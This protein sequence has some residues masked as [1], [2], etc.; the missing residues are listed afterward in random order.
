MSRVG[1]R[2]PC[3]DKSHRSGSVTNLQRSSIPVPSSASAPPP[4]GYVR[5]RVESRSR[6]MR[7]AFH[8]VCVCVGGGNGGG[9]NPQ[10]HPQGEASTYTPGATAGTFSTQFRLWEWP[11]NGADG[12]LRKPDTVWQRRSSRA[13]GG[14]SRGGTYLWHIGFCVWHSL[15]CPRCEWRPLKQTD[16]LGEGGGG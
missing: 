15:G 7:F 12:T 9:G 4:Q 16:W 5:V 11:R 13:L 8:L 10:G 2:Y 3:Q 1:G 6:V 14:S